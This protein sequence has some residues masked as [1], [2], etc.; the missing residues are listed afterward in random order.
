MKAVDFGLVALLW[1]YMY[2]VIYVRLL[3]LTDVFTVQS[4]SKSNLLTTNCFS[5]W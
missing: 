1:S 2:G 5:A 3:T 4:L